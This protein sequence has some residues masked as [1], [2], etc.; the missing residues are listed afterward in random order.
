[1]KKT[2]P[3]FAVLFSFALIFALTSPGHAN[4]CDFLAGLAVL[5]N[6]GE[7]V[8]LKV[9]IGDVQVDF[10]VERDGDKSKVL[11]K[12]DHSN[13]EQQQF[14]GEY[15]KD[16]DDVSCKVKK[17]IPSSQDPFTETS[18]ILDD[19]AIVELFGFAAD[20]ILLEFEPGTNFAADALH[21][22]LTGATQPPVPCPCA[23]DQVDFDA[24]RAAGTLI[25]IFQFPGPGVIN[26]NL[27]VSPL[28]GQATV[29]ATRA[30]L[31]G[32]LF[33]DTFIP[34]ICTIVRGEFLDLPDPHT[35]N[36]TEEEYQACQ[37]FQ[38]DNCF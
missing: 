32:G 26:C 1:M 3:V 28:F 10:K 37:Q 38:L 15:E 22:A 6:D 19:D 31:I 11:F 36:I 24:L 8:E 34:A 16:G 5:A 18:E 12:V 14:I 27:H 13:G 35:I 21:A 25:E 9:D 20:G 2:T 17:D 29:L 23:F 33:G 30:S 4:I 7:T